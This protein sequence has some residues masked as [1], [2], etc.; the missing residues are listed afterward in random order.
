MINTITKFVLVLRGLITK[1][2]ERSV[3]AKK[4]ILASFVIKGGSIAVSLVSVPLTIHYVS[5][6]QYG[7]W[8]TLSSMVGWFGFF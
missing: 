4:N 2:H 6:P 1:G 3:K 8:L 5:P 7:I